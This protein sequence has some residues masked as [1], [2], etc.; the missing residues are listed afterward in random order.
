MGSDGRH[1]RAP[2]APP[3]EPVRGPSPGPSPS[4]VAVAQAGGFGRRRSVGTCSAGFGREGSVCRGGRDALRPLCG[5]LGSGRGS[6][7]I[8]PGGRT[9]S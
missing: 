4:V 1:T 9:G 2:H 5:G 8:L 7:V 6:G 3:A